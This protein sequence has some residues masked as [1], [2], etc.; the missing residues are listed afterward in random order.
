MKNKNEKL[1]LIISRNTEL[2]KYS[3]LV[4]DDWTI[5]QFNSNVES[6]LTDFEEYNNKVERPAFYTELETLLNKY[7]KDNIYRK[8]SE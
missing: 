4:Q 5:S 6:I 8:P 3:D 2:H 1:K 7:S